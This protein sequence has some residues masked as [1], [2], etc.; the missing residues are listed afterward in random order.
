MPDRRLARSVWLTPWLGLVI[1]SMLMMPGASAQTRC[2][3]GVAPGSVLC[4]PDLPQSGSGSSRTIVKIV[5]HW[6]K[7]WGAIADS[8][9]LIGGVST[10]ELS[11]RAAEQRALEA[12]AERGGHSCVV[13]FT[14]FNQCMALIDPHIQGASNFAQTAGSIEV[15]S[16]LGLKLCAEKSGPGAS[17]EVVYSDCTMPKYRE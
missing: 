11:K 10:G 1:V 7:T 5:G 17:C 8:P 3:G 13:S 6:D 2:P 16:E 9:N 14:Y 15:A 12:C 4:Q